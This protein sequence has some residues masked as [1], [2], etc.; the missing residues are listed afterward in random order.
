[1]QWEVERKE[2]FLAWFSETYKRVFDENKYPDVLIRDAYYV[3]YEDGKHNFAR[4]F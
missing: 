1:M 2:C 4:Q 3:G